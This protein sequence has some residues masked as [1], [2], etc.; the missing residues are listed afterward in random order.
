MTAITQG[1]STF[2]TLHMNKSPDTFTTKKI[3]THKALAEPKEMISYYSRK[4]ETKKEHAHI[5]AAIMSSI[6]SMIKTQDIHAH[7]TDP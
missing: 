6:Q 3:F 5:K 1:W 2:F 7:D 4:Y